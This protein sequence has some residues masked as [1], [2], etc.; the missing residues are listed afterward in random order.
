MTTEIFL[1]DLDYSSLKQSVEF[2][3]CRRIKDSQFSDYYLHMSYFV[4][5]DIV[6]DKWKT[7]KFVTDLLIKDFDFA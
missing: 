2:A 7:I 6:A 5:N 1:D 3:L 4:P